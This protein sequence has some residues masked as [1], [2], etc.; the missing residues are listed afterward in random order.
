[1]RVRSLV[2]FVMITAL[3]ALSGSDLLAARIRGCG[4]H[5][6]CAK[7]ICKMT[8]KSGARVDRCGT[9][10]INAPESTSPML[11]TSIDGFVLAVLSS[12][13]HPTITIAVADGAS[14]GVDRPPRA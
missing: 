6:C 4:P 8:P 3:A 7:G 5:P 12:P 1:M 9:D 14:F 11:L 13:T 2:A 10:Q